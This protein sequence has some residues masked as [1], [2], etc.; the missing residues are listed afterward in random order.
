M[1]Q[2][3]RVVVCMKWGTL[4]PAEYVNVL[5]NAVKANLRPPF[6]FICFTDISDGIHPD[7]DVRPI[8]DL[9]LPER[10][11]RSGAWPKISVFAPDAFDF[12]GRALFID[13]DSVICGELDS[14]FEGDQSFRAIGPS[15]WT[16]MPR[17]KPK[18]YHWMKSGLK[19]LKRKVKT[20]PPVVP[21]SNAEEGIVPNSMGTGI[22][23]FNIGE[24]GYVVDRLTDDID[25]ALENYIFEQHFIQNQ[26]REWQ[27]WPDKSICSLKYHLR[28]PVLQ[29]IFKHPMR[30]PSDISIVAFHGDPRPID[31]VKKWHSSRREF[32]NM[33]FGRVKW[34]RE[35]WNANN[36]S[37]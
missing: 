12:T 25:Y 22:F 35:Y 34:V 37:R 17:P 3:E 32:P 15:S 4:Y 13:L 14:F 1:N 16:Q 9:G 26:L 20:V 5:F 36:I 2:D 28:R 19:S 7:V 31:M 27:P 10:A 30:P 33:W 8:V 21:M 6:R 24:Y 18:L 23:A 11:W 29:S